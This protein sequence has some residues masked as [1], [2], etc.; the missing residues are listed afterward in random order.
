MIMVKKLPTHPGDVVK[1]EIEERNISQKYFAECL[2]VSYTMLN[3]ILNCKRPVTCDFALM[4]EK[5]L[6]I[7]SEML[8]NMQSRYNMEAAKNQPSL[9]SRLKKIKP[10]AAMY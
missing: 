6:G 5:A 10:I 2:G 3:E 1:E 4:I 7:N 9:L 8:M